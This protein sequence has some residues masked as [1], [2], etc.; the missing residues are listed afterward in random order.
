[1]S[2]TIV[3]LAHTVGRQLQELSA[4]EAARADATDIRNSHDALVEVGQDVIKTAGAFQHLRE[5]LEPDGARSVREDVTLIAQSLRSSHEAFARDRRQAPQVRDLVKRQTLKALTT[6]TDAWRTAANAR[7]RP[8]LE[9]L[10][11]VERLPEMQGQIND[12]RQLRAQLLAQA[13]QLP[14]STSQLKGFDT[15]CEALEKVLQDMRGLSESVK[16]FLARVAERQAT[17]DDLSEETLAWCRQ[18]SRSTAFRIVFPETG[19]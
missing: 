6:L 16:A 17:L 15:G 10:A 5:R 7:L 9:L 12:A 18:G 8:S 3:T 14:R 1:M 11:L 2:E 19:D 4:L 13:N